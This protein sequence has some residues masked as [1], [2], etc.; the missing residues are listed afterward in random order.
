MELHGNR[1]NNDPARQ[2]DATVERVRDAR[3]DRLDQAETL[4][5]S[6]R[7]AKDS[8]ELSSASRLFG[9]EAPTAERAA[10][11][12]SLKVAYESGNLNTTER[13]ERAAHRLLGGE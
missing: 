12:E 13:M 11:I 8:L 2:R 5:D 3:A 9:A 10:L 6:V 1:L 4:R 7:E